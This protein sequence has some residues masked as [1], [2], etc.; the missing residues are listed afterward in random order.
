MKCT[1]PKEEITMADLLQLQLFVSMACALKP[2]VV[3]H[4]PSADM[5]VY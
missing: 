2:A 1:C 3:M 4:A 5:L